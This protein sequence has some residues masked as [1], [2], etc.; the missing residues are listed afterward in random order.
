MIKLLLDSGATVT[1]YDPEANQ[2]TKAVLGDII[3]YAETSEETLVD[4]DALI[5]VTEWKEFLTLDFNEMISLLKTPIF[6]DGRNQ[7]DKQRM[8]E[9]GFEYYQ[10]GVTEQ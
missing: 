1:A 4:A 5:V 7:F 8:E 3:K 6:F 10:I 2:T 9:L